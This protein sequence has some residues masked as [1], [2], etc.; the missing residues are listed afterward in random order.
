MSDV[1]KS[2]ENRFKQEP[3]D[4]NQGELAPLPTGGCIYPPNSPLYMKKT[5]PILYMTAEHED[6]LNSRI[7]IKQGI[8]LDK[9]LAALVIDKSIDVGELIVGDKNAILLF[10][11]IIGYGASYEVSEM[12]CDSC[13]KSFTATVHLDKI[14]IRK[15]GAEPIENGKNL[16]AYTLPRTKKIAKFHLLT[17]KDDAEIDEAEEN[18][19]KLKGGLV[20]QS[21]PITTRLIKQIDEIEEVESKNKA[22]FIR[23]MPAYDSAS[24]RSYIDDITP[25]PTMKQDVVCPHCG[26]SKEQIIPIGVEFFW[27]K[28]LA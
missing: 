6:V 15:L 11:R 10:A 20:L 8:V 13:G 28:S 17:T 16:F 26:D 7:F 14:D 21:Q 27:P 3:T 2:I 24:L 25:G 1:D 4:G 9:L 5:I 19:K 22:D 23:K 12:K 18:K